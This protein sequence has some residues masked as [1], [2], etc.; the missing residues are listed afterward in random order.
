MKR[1]TGLALEKEDNLSK[2]KRL[3][4]STCVEL[5]EDIPLELELNYNRSKREIALESA[6]LQRKM[7][8]CTL[9]I[10]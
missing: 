1:I 7:K 4:E 10:Q 5:K 8:K 9:K 6:R 2:L 3:N